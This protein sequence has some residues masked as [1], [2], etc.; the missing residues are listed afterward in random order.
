MK[1]KTL[2]QAVADFRD[3]I[4]YVRGLPVILDS[5]LARV[6]GVTTG[7]LNQAVKRNLDRF[8]DEFLFIIQPQEVTRLISQI[9]IS[10][11]PTQPLYSSGLATRG[12][13]GRRKAVYAF[14]EHGAIMAS[15]ILNT[16]QAVR[17]SVFV[18]KAF[19]AM[20]SLLLTQQDLAK[21][22]ADL[23][24]T[25]TERLDTHEHAISDI[26]QQIMQLLSPPPAP[27]GEEPPRPRIGFSVRERRA[28]YRTRKAK[29]EQRTGRHRVDWFTPRPEDAKMRKKLFLPLCLRVLACGKGLLG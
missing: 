18:V 16:P 22:L 3:F 11:D 9:V 29:T 4:V 20:R 24:R 27:D 2:S 8:P 12:R 23:E 28:V 26:I 7:A 19:V 13:G 5:D 6:Y 17:M 21:K 15:M 25:L 1:K 14:T 10:N